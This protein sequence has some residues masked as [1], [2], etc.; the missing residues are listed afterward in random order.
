MRGHVQVRMKLLENTVVF[1]Q[2]LACGRFV[3][4]K[5]ISLAQH[6]ELLVTTRLNLY[7]TCIKWTSSLLCSMPQYFQII[8]VIGWKNLASKSCSSQPRLLA[9]SSSRSIR[10][11]TIPL[12]TSRLRIQVSFTF[13]HRRTHPLLLCQRACLRTGL[14]AATVQLSHQS[15]PSLDGTCCGRGGPG[16]SA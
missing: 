16:T 6:R 14:I 5:T 15:A 2:L 11:L 7:C 9:A 10:L 8:A 1:P 3:A 4:T 13:T 12:V